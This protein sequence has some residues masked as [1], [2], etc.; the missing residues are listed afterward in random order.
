MI[1]SPHCGKLHAFEHSSSFISSPSSHSSTPVSTTPSVQT[2][3]VQSDLHASLSFRLAS[4][5]SSPRSTDESPQKGSL[6]LVNMHVISSPIQRL[7]TIP[8]G[9]A[10]PSAPPSPFV[11]V[12]L[13]SVHP[14]GILLSVIV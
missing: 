2:L 13:D 11:Q 4:S 7:S 8:F 9:D 5:H 1:K 6:S 10:V 3:N 14:A 12:I